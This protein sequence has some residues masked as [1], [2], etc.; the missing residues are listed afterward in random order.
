MEYDSLRGDKYFVYQGRTKTGKPK[1]YASKK[2]TSKAGVRVESLPDEFE[3]FEN[4][5]NCV[6]SIRRRKPSRILASE[7]DLIDRMAVELSAYSCVRTIIDGDRIVVYTPDTD[8]VESAMMLEQIFGPLSS[9]KIEGWTKRNAR[10][11]AEL[12]FTLVDEEN[13]YF[14]TDRFCYRGSI[15][16]WIQIAERAPLEPM[17]EK[18]LQHFGRD[19][20]YDLPF[21]N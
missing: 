7:R 16:D 6:V 10:Y 11:T 18:L 9:T 20:F 12:R 21:V 3:L 2:P 15:D 5:S 14:T 1:F 8:P 17:A 4:P 19:S 13:R